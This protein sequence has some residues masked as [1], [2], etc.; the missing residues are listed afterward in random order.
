LIKKQ[1]PFFGHYSVFYRPRS[2]VEKLKGSVAA[3]VAVLAF[4]LKI[5]HTRFRLS[6][7]G[8]PVQG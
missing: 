1:G 7:S 5:G 3:T 8:F 2:V 6:G 4:C